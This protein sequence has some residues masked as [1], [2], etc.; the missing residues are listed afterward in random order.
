M[1]TQAATDDIVSLEG[2]EGNV[3]A[4]CEPCSP[5]ADAFLPT[6]YGNFRIRGFPELFDKDHC[7]LYA[8]RPW[9]EEAPLIRI[10]SECLTGDAFGSIK[11]DCGAQLQLAQARLQEEGAGVILY[12]RQEGRGIGLSNKIKAY[13]LQDRGL[14]TLDANL[15]LGLPAD[16]RDY[17]IAAMMLRAMGIQRVRLLTNNPHKEEALRVN[18]IEIVKRVEH[19]DGVCAQNEQYLATKAARMGHK[20]PQDSLDASTCSPEESDAESIAM[21]SAASLKSK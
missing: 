8:G 5:D 2:A 1:L 3:E 4:F 18:G 13:A 19:I 17:S 14:D 21:S 16:G 12:L 10:H 9:E 6:K 15:A 20:L 11:C 7:A